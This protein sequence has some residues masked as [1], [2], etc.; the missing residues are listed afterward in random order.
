LTSTSR[1]AK[2]R[3]EAY[4]DTL[5]E[6][7]RIT[8]RFFKLFYSSPAA[9]ALSRLDGYIID[10]NISFLRIFEYKYEEAANH[11]ILELNLYPNLSN[12]PELVKVLKKNQNHYNYDFSTTSKTGK[13]LDLIASADLID[14][15]EQD[16]IFTTFIDNTERKKAEEAL[17]LSEENYRHIVQ[18]APTAI[19]EIESTN[20][21]FKSVND[22]MCQMTGYTQE[23]LLTM[24][25]FDLLDENSKIRF[26]E[27]IKKVLAGE[28]VAERT[29]YRSI[30]KDGTER[31]AIVSSKLR[32][33]D[34]KFDSALIVALDITEQ[35][36]LQAKLE[37]Y[38]RDLERQVEKLTKQLKDAKIG[39]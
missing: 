36:Q 9:M 16:C 1:D 13:H 10:V 11:T 15:E 22:V 27:R 35:K 25:P 26:Q 5:G 32:F 12:Q 30:G 38:N 6:L 18:F 2:K 28:K 29:E 19:Y 34:G 3:R 17:R 23:E 7:N 24:S 4:K 31:W 33:K 8:E 20:S 14:F 39:H 21:S 37:D